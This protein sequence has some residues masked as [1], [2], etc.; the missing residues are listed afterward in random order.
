MGGCIEVLEMAKGTSLWPDAETFEDAILFFETS[1]DMPEPCYI[2]YWLR[3]YGS[4][5]ILQKAKALLFGKPYQE[6]FYDEYKR[7]I[8]KIISELRLFELPVFYN[9]SFGH[10]EP[11][12]IIPYGALAEV[13]CEN[14]TFTILESGVI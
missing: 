12:C 3:N 13:D 9:M 2:E 7:A 5:G 14:R 4:L 1:E 11:M 10:N 8:M 6:R